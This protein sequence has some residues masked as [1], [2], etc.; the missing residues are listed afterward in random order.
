M[1][2]KN[3]KGTLLVIYLPPLHMKKTF[4]LFNIV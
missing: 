4:E 3:Y 2:C 1:F